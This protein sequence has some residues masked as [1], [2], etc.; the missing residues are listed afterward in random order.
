[1]NYT[2]YIIK[3][4]NKGVS[5]QWLR[6]PRYS[7]ILSYQSNSLK[8]IF[9]ERKTVYEIERFSLSEILN[10]TGASIIFKKDN[11]EIKLHDLIHILPEEFV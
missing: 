5:Y 3:H 11:Q 10:Q 6:V 7:S 9:K 1:M 2:E 8:E 4:T